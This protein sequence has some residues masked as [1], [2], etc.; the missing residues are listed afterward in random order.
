KPDDTTIANATIILG[1]TASLSTESENLE[2]FLIAT[3]VMASVA[4][5]FTIS[6]VIACYRYHSTKKKR[7]TD[8]YDELDT[9]ITDRV[10]YHRPQVNAQ[11]SSSSCAS[12]YLDVVSSRSSSPRD[13]PAEAGTDANPYAEIGEMCMAGE[14]KTAD[15]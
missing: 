2:A 6:T 5:S 10:F 4:A 9:R 14:S 1:D 15:E 3:V 13:S 12:G 7:L 11:N 8:N